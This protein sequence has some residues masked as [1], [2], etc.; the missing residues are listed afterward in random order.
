MKQDTWT[1]KPPKPVGELQRETN[2]TAKGVSNETL[3]DISK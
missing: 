3:L 2:N 1:A